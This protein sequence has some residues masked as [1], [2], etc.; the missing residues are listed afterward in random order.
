MTR[1]RAPYGKVPDVKHLELGADGIADELVLV[2]HFSVVRGGNRAANKA[3][4]N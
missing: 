1:S 3:T 2:C 4:P